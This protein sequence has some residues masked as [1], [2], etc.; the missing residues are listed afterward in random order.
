MKNNITHQVPV[1]VSCR[2]KKEYNNEYGINVLILNKQV[3]FEHY[4]PS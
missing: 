2:N 1:S 4:L 3:Y